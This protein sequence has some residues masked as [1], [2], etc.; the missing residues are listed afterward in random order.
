MDILTS[1]LPVV[2]V[3]NINLGIIIK[4]FIKPL[5]IIPGSYYH[6]NKYIA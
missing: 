5:I 2:Y 4:G 1:G 6:L 3:P